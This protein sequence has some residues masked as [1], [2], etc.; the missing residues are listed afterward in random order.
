MMRR[1]TTRVIRGQNQR[2]LLAAAVA[3]LL[4]SVTLTA[5]ATP[6]VADACDPAT[7]NAIACENLK[8]GNDKSEWDV[9][10]GSPDIEGFATDISTNVGGT[11][12]FKIHSP[13]AYQI[14]IYR[15]GY[16]GG[17]GAR[18]IQSVTPNLPVSQTNDANKEHCLY[19]EDTGLLDCGVW[20]V[21]ATWAVPATAVSGIYFARITLND[22]DEN[23][24]QVENHIVFVVRN[25]AS[26]SK[27]VFQTS[28]TTWQAYNDWGGNSFYNGLPAGRAFK[29]SYNRPFN[30]RTTPGGRDFVWANEYPM[31]RFLEANG[32]DVTYQ[33]GIDTDRFGSTLTQ[34]KVFLSVGHDEYWSG[35]QRANVEAARDAGVNLAFFSANEVFWKTRY[36]SSV[37]A[38]GGQN[39]RTIVTY[40]ES[41]DGETTANNPAGV[42]TGTW[43]DPRFSPP[44][45]GGKP[46]NGLT[47]TIFRANKG[48]R[49]IQVPAADGKLRF[50]RDTPA[51][52]LTTGRTTLPMGTLG[53][54]WDEDLDNGFRP[55][56][57]IQM[58][59]STYTVPEK[60]V[61][62]GT[63]V[64]S[65]S[66]T[67]H[68]MLY[69]A[70]SGALV[71]GA[72]TVQWSWGLDAN[73][74]YPGEPD[75]LD[76]DGPTGAP[77]PTDPNM[78]QATV[79]LLADMD[80]Q[81]STLQ[82]PL[83][84]ATKSTDS[85]PATAVIT[86]PAT[87]ASVASGSTVTVSGTASDA[88][89]GQVGGVEV[90]TD[91]GQS[92]HPANGRESWT[93]T[94][95]VTG[96]GATTVLAR[97][98]DD[99]A[100]RQT[101]PTPKQVQVACPCA[102][103]GA[104]AP[105]TAS[106]PDTGSME[107][108]V[109]FSPK[110]DG[111]VTGVR[112][113]KGPNNTGI[114]TGTLWSS[115]GTELATGTFVG[116][117][118]GG[119][120][121][122]QF[123]TAVPV[124]AGSTYV[125]SYH[126]PNGGYSTT[127]GYFVGTG[128]EQYPLSAPRTTDDTPNGVYESGDRSF[129]TRTFGGGNYWVSPVFD[130][131]EPP[132]TTA[133]VAISSVPVA[134]ASSVRV[135][136]VPRLTFSEPIKAGTLTLGLSSSGG[137][138]A[139]TTSLNSSRTTATFTP[140]SPLANAT[141]YMFTTTGGTD[142]AGN[143]LPASGRTF[144]TAASSTPGVCPCSIWS[145]SDEPTAI[146]INDPS[147]VE[148]GVKFRADQNGYVAG[149]RFYKGPENVGTHT[150][151]LWSAGGTP[152]A[153]ATFGP[154][155]T[156]GWQEVRFS[157][158]VAVT[159]GTT[160]VA[161]YHTAG[162][163]SATA[164][165]LDDD[166]TN[167]PLTALGNGSDGANAVYG[168]GPH[169]F[170]N[171][172]GNGTSYG[173][174]VVFELPPDV[175]APGVAGT[176]P[177]AGASNVRTSTV[178]SATFT[179]PIAGGLTGTLKTGSTPVAATVALDA[180]RRTATVTP[181]A[182]LQ[183]DTTYTVTLGGAKDAAGNTM[184]APYSWTFRTSGSQSCPCTLY[185][186]DHVPAVTATADATAL[187][188]G[189]R[190]Q[191]VADG[192]VTGVR[193]YKGNGNTGTHVGRLW[194]SAGALIT[195]A[196]FTGESATGW[197]QVTFA[198]PVTV[199]A[200]T[201]YVA[202]YSD[203]LGR[204]AADAGQLSS[205]WVNGPL[206]AL[207][208]GSGGGNGVY[209]TTPGRFPEASFNATGYGVDVVFTAGS[210]ADTVAPTLVS[211]NPVDGATGV[212]TGRKPSARFDEALAPGSV[213]AT[214]TGPGTSP[215]ATTVTVGTTG[216]VTLTPTAA[217]APD[218]VYSARID[219]T[220]LAGN[221]LAGP[222]QWTFRTAK[223]PTTACPC[224]LWTD[225]AEPEIAAD[226]DDRAIEVGVKFTPTTD[227]TV[228][229]L[230]FYKGPGNTGSHVGTL[231]SGSGAQLATATFT[232][233]SA[234]GWQ[235]VTFAQPVPVIAGTQYVA[236]YHAPQGRFAATIGG[237]ATEGVTRG[238]LTAP[239]AT[240]TDPNGVYGYGSRAFP[241]SGTNT[242]YWV[243]VVFE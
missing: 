164:A 67:H 199:T 46:E 32:Y 101:T 52:R 182:G 140:T 146:T 45:D 99:S 47:G 240:A 192:F 172:G 131:V 38:A 176:S 222:V 102:L 39:Y 59:S 202:S 132:D 210:P 6:A 233:E 70:P 17:K 110:L 16:Y 214:L 128:T 58:S 126:A 207:A 85:T 242:N 129:P 8:T 42:W 24:N 118:S 133:P 14:R 69:R 66:V 76:P 208:N 203:P 121:N 23:G 206:I 53:Y 160:Y 64:Q 103:F 15:M 49:A 191:A 171:N 56:G 189:V 190:F 230:R 231:W 119:W 201:T 114:H 145:D 55:P 31:V 168:Y 184:A 169:A 5:V 120:Q 115:A 178:P 166:V 134:G 29:L 135:T 237:F 88:G 193:F 100:N 82:S 73:H 150:G 197:Q 87:G 238:P 174:D 90:S 234:A 98:T 212:P 232:S 63:D 180:N 61:G 223:A 218:T 60:L 9:G 37:A 1:V 217:L 153:T 149:I 40:K 4:G 183:P 12:A 124:S 139:G 165:T 116:E 79:N 71:F 225:E 97:A 143:P 104:E 25:S 173:V 84:V 196:T 78:Q 211:T 236:S 209:T 22:L 194:T 95:N 151:T 7:G 93:Y 216:T 152:L 33:S 167:A 200:G 229:G 130:L 34:H 187:E 72:G 125:V 77:T 185:P 54:E 213:Q 81:P 18:F 62:Y 28:D 3:L 127:S 177:G 205:V 147:P 157:T 20:G 204:Y 186:S 158:R 65:G 112:F 137:L 188:L 111:F 215:V 148:L 106:D 107:L 74:D 113:Y 86:A 51:S 2:R 43:R 30:T 108:G 181:T 155:S 57:A 239:V 144:R 21:S 227:G 109:R 50:W 161:S 13:L 123:N 91:G 35:P 198:A 105:E 159:A 179:E 26:T 10:N 27:L 96:A 224:S 44:A 142:N 89:G 41:K 117:S 228:T 235:E 162:F 94:W 136:A 163:Y 221:A 68:L 226:D 175:T 83:K 11:V 154:E 195:S 92:W 141:T 156:A 220:D 80:A 48:T 75:E 138:V 243:D 36:E 219:G 19:T 170:P 122:L 241:T